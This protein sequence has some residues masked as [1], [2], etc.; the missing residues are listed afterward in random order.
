VRKA[1]IKRKTK[2]TDIKLTLD[3]DTP[4]DGPVDTGSAFLDHMLDLLRKHSG[5]GLSVECKGDK[6]IDMPG[7]SALQSRR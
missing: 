6:D 5:I 3:L 1:E 7:R 4:F 2:E